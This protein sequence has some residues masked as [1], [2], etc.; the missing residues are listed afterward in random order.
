MVPVGDALAEDEFSIVWGVNMPRNI[1][2]IGET[3]TVEIIATAS[4]DPNLFVPGEMALVTIRN[5]S[6]QECYAAWLTTND[7]GTIIAQWDIPL[8][9][10][11]GNY[12]FVLAPIMSD[13]IIIPFLVL[14]DENTYWQ[15]RVENL[16][17]ELKLQYEY[18][19][20]LYSSNNYLNKQVAILKDQVFIAGIIMFVTLM[21]TM[22][23]V[24]P[25]WARRANQS[26]SK[27]N[28]SSKLAKLMGFSSTPKVLLTEHH[29]ELAQLKTPIGMKPPRYGMVHHCSICDPESKELMTRKAYIEH[30]EFHTRHVISLVKWRRERV[31]RAIISDHYKI[32]VDDL[33]IEKTARLDKRKSDLIDSVELAKIEL[34]AIN[35]DSRTQKDRDKLKKHQGKAAE[36]KRAKEEK[37]LA[38]LAKKS[39]EKAEPVLKQTVSRK[40]VN[41]RTIRREKPISGIP[42]A[43]PEKKLKV[44]APRTPIDDLFEKLSSEKVN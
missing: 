27:E 41:T 18:L 19:N 39:V 36:K 28:M 8:E 13:N 1:Y 4:T 6:L 21:A 32:P 22:W 20:Y 7:N 33:R 11:T 9:M 42:E 38:K 29:E 16:E 15:K 17:E 3:M 14:Y 43:L 31:Y 24:I 25:E 26:E 2:F 30:L 40:T 37:R 35:E 23:V 34:K 5:E 10:D 44:D 12:T